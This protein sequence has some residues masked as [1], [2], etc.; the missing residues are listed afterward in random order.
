M[1]RSCSRRRSSASSRSPRRPGTASVAALAR[2]VDEP[3]VAAVCAAA[4]RAVAP[5]ASGVFCFDVREDR[6]GVPCVTE[7][8]AGRFSMST[9]LYDLVGKHN[10]ASSYVRLALGEPVNVSDEYDAVEGYYMVRDLDTLP[11]IFHADELADGIED[12]RP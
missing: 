10:M 3:R 5:R 1:G 4:I 7:I 8:N 11:G 12:A 2:T 9:N 6:R